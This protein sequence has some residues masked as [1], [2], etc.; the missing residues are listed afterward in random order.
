MWAKINNCDDSFLR[1]AM[2]WEI[3]METFRISTSF[4]AF[5]GPQAQTLPQVL[6]VIVFCCRHSPSIVC[7]A[8]TKSAK[9]CIGTRR[10]GWLSQSVPVN[11]ATCI[12]T[13]DFLFLGDFVDRGME[14]LPVVA[15]V[16]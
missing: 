2:C 14:S 9:F 5:F 4:A 6:N 1:L 8:G 12:F 15:Y 11:R 16:M 3:F 7:F 10:V 13:G